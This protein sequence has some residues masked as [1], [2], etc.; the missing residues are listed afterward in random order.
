MAGKSERLIWSVGAGGATVGDFHQELTKYAEITVRVGLNLQKGQ[1]LF[2]TA[3]L[4]AVEYVRVV[5]RE[6][7]VV[8][9]KH[10][11]VEWHDEQLD[12]LKYLHAPEE[13]FSEFPKWRVQQGEQ[14]VEA[15]AALLS[16]Y[17]SDPDL[18]QAADPKRVATDQKTRLTAMAKM[19]EA[20]QNM[21]ISWLIVSIPTKAWAA[22]IFPQLTEKQQID[23]LWEYIFKTTRVDLDDPV[24]E[25]KKHIVELQKRAAFLNEHNFR[26]LHYQAPGTDLTIEFPEGHIWISAESTNAQG[27]MFV[28][29]MPTEEVFTLPKRD[30]VNG[31]VTSTMPLH[32]NGVLV[33]N[34]SLTFENGRIV[35]FS[36]D[37]G[38]E[39]IQGLVETDEGSH[40]LGEVALVPHDSPISNLHTL[41]FNTLFD[42]NAACHLAIGSAYPVCLK[43]GSEMDEDTLR[44]HDVNQ[45]VEH[46][47]FMI[48]SKDLQIDGQTVKGEW[49]PIFRNGNWA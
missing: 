12:L 11:H 36:A 20:I 41:F 45:S 16:I 31:V 5:T 43:G 2:I 4:E 22:K 14:L 10:V 8:G 6:A 33:E 9:A 19:R 24:A 28:P 15:G 46:V 25:W 27:T 49:M 7:Y 40:Y 29:N 1:T 39:A 42:E 38:Y 32:Y 18:L 17:A 30:G 47:D 13:A 23:K 3:P 21:R 37:R 44:Q 35:E 48:G 26:K 34:L